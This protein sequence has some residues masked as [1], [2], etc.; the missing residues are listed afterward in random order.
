MIVID[1]GTTSL[2][3]HRLDAVGAIRDSRAA[4]AGIMRVED[5]AFA[6][7]ADGLV[8]DWLTT[9]DAP[10]LLCGMIGS[11]QGWIEA[12]YRA[13]P[14][15]ARDLAGRLTAVPGR[16]SW[17]IVPGVSTDPDGGV[18]DVMRGEETQIVGAMERLGLADA[19]M[20]LPGTHAKWAKVADRRITGFATAMTGELFQVISEHTILRALMATEES[21]DAGAFDAGLARA[22]EPG[23]LPHH[24]FGARALGLF[25]RLGAGA[26][27]SYLSGLLIGH[28]IL[29]TPAALGV[30]ETRDIILVVAGAQ[31]APYVRAL[32]AFGYDATIVPTEAATIAG[33]TR[34]A[35]LAGEAA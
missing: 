3:A 8:G 21:F 20:L 23:G 16:P 25:G 24:L 26:G 13:C 11:R 10:V 29:S 14:A 22:R 5:R 19:L 15:S 18:P 35:Q 7:V 34:I 28:E 9:A 32:A 6:A 33:L 27:R 12:P 31:E 2:R 17:R 1:W 4:P 30:A